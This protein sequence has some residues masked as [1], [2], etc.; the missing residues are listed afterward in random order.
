MSGE[1]SVVLYSIP[2][3]LADFGARVLVH[4]PGLLNLAEVN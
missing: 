2:E 3:E 4:R 1:W